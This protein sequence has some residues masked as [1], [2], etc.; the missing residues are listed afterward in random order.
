MRSYPIPSQLPIDA[1]RTEEVFGY[2]PIFIAPGQNK[3]V[4]CICK[5][6]K[7]EFAVRRKS[8]EEGILCK[9]CRATKSWEGRTTD[10][11]AI[12]AESV[13]VDDETEKRFGYKATTLSPY[14]FEKVV[15]RCSC[16]ALFE[17]IRRNVVPNAICVPCSYKNRMSEASVA[18]RAET[19]LKK[20]G[21]VGIPIP[22]GAYGKVEDEL[23][24][25]LQMWTNEEV[26]RQKPLDGGHR[27]DFL[28]PERKI[29]IEYCGLFWHNEMSPTPRGPQYHREKMLECD[30]LG[31]R[32]ITIFEDEWRDRNEQCK[33]LLRAQLGS[34]DRKVDARKGIVKEISLE[35][36]RKFLNNHHL[37]GSVLRSNKAWGFYL[38]EELLSVMTFGPHP[39]QS[40]ENVIIL[41]RFA[42]AS[43][44]NVRGG[45]SKLFNTAMAWLKES[46]VEKVVSWSDNRWSTGRVYSKLG[47]SLAEN[48]PPDYSYVK[49]AC[50]RE[51]LSKQSQ[52]KNR[53]ACP[54]GL[55]E[56]E[57][58]TQR[59]LA[60]VWDCGKKRWERQVSVAVREVE[61]LHGQ[62]VPDA[63][64]EHHVSVPLNHVGLLLDVQGSV[65]EDIVI[66]EEVLG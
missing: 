61:L 58:A 65:L 15:G 59:G 14:S 40:H 51:R 56:S 12:N 8:V 18:R 55:T 29:A 27:L 54:E 64:T 17:R 38:E 23:A 66:S 45:A 19:F 49:A 43:G 60:R 24:R 36:S 37:Q 10:I 4:I 7:K 1:V 62:S 32:L 42:V 16:G 5:N 52:K 20:Y 13:L 30:V 48:L 41:D 34:F 63:D 39:R 11:P 47:F 50:P 9:P 31:I 44:I 26:I 25:Y 21:T 2:S 28:L 57:W 53:T 3:K 33:G 46:C 22:P 35:E 6:C